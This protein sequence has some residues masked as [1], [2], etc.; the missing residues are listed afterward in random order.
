MRTWWLLGLC[1]AWPVAAIPAPQAE[2]R[3]EAAPAAAVAAGPAQA[4]EAAGA[5]P[6]APPTFS[7]AGYAIQ[8]PGQFHRGEPVARDG[9][10]W[11]ALRIDRMDAAL[12]SV[13]V[14]VATVEDPLVDEPGGERTGQAVST[15]RPD[16]AVVMLLRGPALVPGTLDAATQASQATGDGQHRIDT[17]LAFRG[18]RHHLRSACTPRGAMPDDGQR[19]FDCRIVLRDDRGREQVLVR[20]DGY[21]DTPGAAPLL[22][23]DAMP[24]LLFAGDLDRDGELDL[25]FDTTDHYNRSSP[26]LF[27]SSQAAPGELLGKVASYDSVGC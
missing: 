2:V 10:R 15:D 22:G 23:D 12:V 18:T 20:M 5:A 1:G 17:V 19:R 27:L 24:A 7:I 26:T 3:V 13:I 25:L 16:E 14:Q 8:P 9:E 11:L 21:A 6:P 4:D